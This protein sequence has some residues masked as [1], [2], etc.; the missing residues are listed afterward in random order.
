MLTP[1]LWFIGFVATQRLGELVLARHNTA[2]LLARGAREIGAGH[3]PAI[4][5]MHASWLLAIAVLGWNQPVSL[6]WLAAYAVLQGFRVWILASLGSR[7]TTR[8]IV[9][10]EPLVVR[11][12][13]R[14]VPHPNYMLVVA[15][16][17]VTPMVLGLTW[18]AAVF[19]LLNAAVLYVRIST[20]HKALRG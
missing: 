8:I 11:G 19:T 4:V 13:Y 15:E 7:W 16:I 12:P 1:A 17:I 14:F 9:L 6:P 18:V 10:D 2:R 20:E 5:A 3:Y